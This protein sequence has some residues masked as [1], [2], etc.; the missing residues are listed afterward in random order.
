MISRAA[1]IKRPEEL[2]AN[3]VPKRVSLV[4]GLIQERVREA[5]SVRRGLGA[6]SRLGADDDGG[7]GLG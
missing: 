7:P 3:Y 4:N 1:A 2:V 5:A 6:P